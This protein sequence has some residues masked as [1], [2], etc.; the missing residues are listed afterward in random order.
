MSLALRGGGESRHLVNKDGK[1]TTG[2]DIRVHR[3]GQ[4]LSSECGSE[5][6][7]GMLR[8]LTRMSGKNGSR[9]REEK[10]EQLITSSIS[11]SL[12]LDLENL[13]E[14]PGVITSEPMLCVGWTRT[15][16]D[17]VVIGL[18]PTALAIRRP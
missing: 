16:S 6:S 9:G 14:L 3:R 11:T 5:K 1:S 4:V 15:T 18:Q 8:G 12:I 13:S 2:V 7:T 17:R 10:G